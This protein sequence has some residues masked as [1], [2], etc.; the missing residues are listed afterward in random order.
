[1]STMNR[2]IRLHPGIPDQAELRGMNIFDALSET[3]IPEFGADNNST[4]IGVDSDEEESLAQNR[5][6]TDTAA[7]VHAFYAGEQDYRRRVLYPRESYFDRV[8]TSPHITLW[9][10][11]PVVAGRAS[12][13]VEESYSFLMEDALRELQTVREEAEEA[14]VLDND[15]DPV[16]ESA[17]D[18]AQVLLKML[19]DSNSPM[20]DIGWAEDGSLGFEWRPEDGI[21]TMGIY[22]DSLV[23]YGA[24]FED[25]RQVEGICTLADIAMLTGFMLMLFPSVNKD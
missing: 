19:F 3:E 6:A 4:L 24:F 7:E 10:P 20:P 8:N 21:A 13:S 16:P 18:D 17:Y 12:S 2:Q 9:A 15:I 23:I 22:G 1:M 14:Y 11:T 5:S 25:K